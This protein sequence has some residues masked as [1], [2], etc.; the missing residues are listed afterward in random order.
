MKNN[1]TDNLNPTSGCYYEIDR[2]SMVVADA[3]AMVSAIVFFPVVDGK[4]PVVLHTTAAGEKTVF[5]PNERL[6]APE[7]VAKAREIFA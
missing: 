4:M 7:F 6:Y 5:I 1:K 2:E 3:G